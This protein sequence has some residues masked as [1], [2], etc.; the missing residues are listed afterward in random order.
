M[1]KTPVRSFFICT[2]NGESNCKRFYVEQTLL[3]VVKFYFFRAE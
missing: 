1:L 2:E 3:N